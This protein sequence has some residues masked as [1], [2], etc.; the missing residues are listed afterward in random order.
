M[1]RFAAAAVVYLVS[2][3]VTGSAQQAQQPPVPKFRADIKLVVAV[4]SVLAESRV[5]VLGLTAADFTILEDGRPQP[6]SIFTAIDA[7]DVEVPT[8][9]WMK[10][11]APDVRSNEEQAD[12][13]LM[14][15]VLDDATPTAAADVPQVRSLARRVIFRVGPG[16]LAAVGYVLN[17]KE[18]QEFMGEA[19]SYASNAARDLLKLVAWPSSARTIPSRGSCR[20]SAGTVRTTCSAAKRQPPSQRASTGASTSASVTAA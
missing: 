10:A 18:G 4:V 20:C 17:K 7:P 8:A 13:R 15:P 16:D 3:I 12:R 11:V 5:P 14:V 9:A 2:A 1:R 6:V 19:G